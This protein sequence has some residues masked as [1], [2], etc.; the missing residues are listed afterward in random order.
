MDLS[1]L[2]RQHKGTIM[3]HSLQTDRSGSDQ[4][5]PEGAQEHSDQGL[6]CL[7]FCLHLLNILFHS[8]TRLFN[9]YDNYGNFFRYPNLSDI[10]VIL[11][12][13]LLVYNSTSTICEPSHER[14]DLSFWLVNLETNMHT[15]PLDT[16]RDVAL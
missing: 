13:S 15:Q 1:V 8:K 10:Y 5:A 16:T 7:L 6:H 14:R 9:F 2:S 12:F 4:T 11:P 3:S